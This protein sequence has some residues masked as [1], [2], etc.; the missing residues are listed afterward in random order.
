MLIS[1]ESVYD[2][3]LR[4]RVVGAHACLILNHCFR[5]FLTLQYKQI[6]STSEGCF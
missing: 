5:G 6:D 4:V 2:R 3:I 1:V